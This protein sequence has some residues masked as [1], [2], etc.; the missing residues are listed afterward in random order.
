MNLSTIIN[1]FMDKRMDMSPLTHREDKSI[2]KLAQDYFGHISDWGQ[3]HPNA[4]DDIFEQI[5][6]DKSVDRRNRVKKKMQ[7][8]IDFAIR[9]QLVKFT[10]N[11]FHQVKLNTVPKYEKR[12]KKHFE[13]FNDVPKEHHT[14]TRLL[15]MAQ[16]PQQKLL[17][18]LSTITG[19]RVNEVL[20]LKWSDINI[21]NPQEPLLKMKNS[22]L[23]IN[24]ESMDKHRLMDIN[25]QFLE[26]IFEQKKLVDKRMEVLKQQYLKDKSYREYFESKHTEIAPTS[27]SDKRANMKWQWVITTK[28]GDK[29]SYSTA[30]M[31]YHK[32]WKDTYNKYKDHEV[33]PF[34]HG[35]K[36]KGLTF[37][38]YRRYYANSYRDSFGE[39]YTKAHHDGLQLRIGHKIGSKVTDDFY[40]DWQNS[41][42]LKVKMNSKINLGFDF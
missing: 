27:K 6:K 2:F 10:N 5:A 9:Y 19:G 41:Q 31:W 32:I 20:D 29:P 25:P 3:L 14:I 35:D 11:P 37:H 13:S 15:E 30:L 33:H 21:K 26:K 16:T 8:L 40:T 24:D 34:M 1:Q 12:D 23:K 18:L 7:Q 22:K 36:P 28:F 38:S 39:D 4:L 42:L 17:I